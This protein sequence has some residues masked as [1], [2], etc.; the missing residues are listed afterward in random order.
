MIYLFN[1]FAGKCHPV[2]YHASKTRRSVRRC[3]S[4]HSPVSG[5]TIRNATIPTHEPKLEI[6]SNKGVYS[7]EKKKV[8]EKTSLINSRIYVP[9]MEFGAKEK[10]N[11]PIPFSDKDSEKKNPP[12]DVFAIVSKNS[13]PVIIALAFNLENERSAGIDFSSHLREHVFQSA[14]DM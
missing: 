7:M 14:F 3:V 4:V 10:F 12:L 11:F 2:L 8:L 5:A 6:T 13:I 9:F 1:C